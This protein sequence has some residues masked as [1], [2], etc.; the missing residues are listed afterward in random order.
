[1]TADAGP[2]RRPLGALLVEAG[3][4]DETQLERA[5]RD[6]AQ[7]GDRLGEVL[8]RRGWASEDDVARLLAKQWGL[9][10][11]DRASIWFDADGLT[12][13]SRED[14]QRLGALPTRV[15]NG[16]VVVA[17]AEPTE[18]RLATL[19]ELIGDTVVVVVPKTA[20]EAG[21]HSELLSSR[22]AEEEGEEEEVEPEPEQKATEVVR[23]ALAPV[24]PPAP[25]APAPGSGS[26]LDDVAN[27]AAQARDLAE[28]LAAQ[29]E[30]A[31]TELSAQAGRRATEEE[32][33]AARRRVD[34]LQSQLVA[35][36]AAVQEVKR[37]LETAVRVIEGGF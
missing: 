7:T 17:V 25:E 27:L 28:L 2:P 29:A 9:R 30:A 22:K 26:A 21:L 34:E 35:Q 31:T 23:P 16:R 6:G 13:L 10:Y 11:V 36:R 33:A 3:L 24:P 15:E 20:L 1:M 4:I 12:R 32:L 5:L 19:A 14:A 37:H 18:Q 8:V